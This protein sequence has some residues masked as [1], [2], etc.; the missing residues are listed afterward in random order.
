MLVLSR[1]TVIR[2]IDVVCTPVSTKSCWIFITVT[3]E[4]GVFG[5]GEATLENHTANLCDFAGQIAGSLVNLSLAAAY[6]QCMQVLPGN[7]VEATCRSALACALIDANARLYEVSLASTLGDV[8]R[9]TVD[10]YANINRR[11]VDRSALSHAESALDALRAGHRAFKVAPFDEMSPDLRHGEFTA[12]L[13]AGLS[14]LEAIRDAVGFEPD[15][16]VDC[17][18]RFSP[19]RLNSLVAALADMKLY[20]LE[21]PVVES[22]ENLKALAACRELCHQHGMLLAGAETACDYTELLPFIESQS[23]DVLMP[24]IRHIGGPEALA[25]CS[26][27]FA[28]NKVHFSPH[29]PVGPVAAAASLQVCAISQTVPRLEMQFDESPCFGTLIRP[30]LGAVVEGKM[31]LPVGPGLGISLDNAVIESIA[32]SDRQVYS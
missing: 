8:Q 2:Q 28:Q 25:L 21:C 11:T 6:A 13:Q 12:A 24:D 9:D 32:N 26:E 14:R 22:P 23:Y 7:M 18:W 19:Q 20:W 1:E 16:M 3:T 31:R 30:S 5:T 17:H 15:L 4:A 29:N 27:R 10:V